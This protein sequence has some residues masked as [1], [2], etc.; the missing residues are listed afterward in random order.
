M[1]D[2]IFAGPDVHVFVDSGVLIVPS[3]RSEKFVVLD[4]VVGGGLPFSQH[5]SPFPGVVKAVVPDDVVMD[6]IQEMDDPVPG[7]PAG[8]AF[9]QAV[10][11]VAHI[12]QI[13]GIPSH[14]AARK[15]LRDPDIV[16]DVVFDGD[17]VAVPGIHGPRIAAFHMGYD[18]ILD[19]DVGGIF[20]VYPDG[21]I[22][23]DQTLYP[24]V[25]PVVQVNGPFAPSHVDGD[26]FIAVSCKSDG[27]SLGSRLR[28]PYGFLVVPFSDVDGVPRL[29][30]GIG[31]ADGAPG[32]VYRAG[33]RIRARS[34]H[35]I[36]IHVKSAS[37]CNNLG[38]LE[39]LVEKI[40]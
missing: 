9:D 27:L 4:Q 23:Q 1:P 25:V 13:A 29:S 11:E 12:D 15:I 36:F 30:G 40:G 3:G 16:H 20:G 22:G 19:G 24:D 31:F 28:G 18:T 34:A 10:M 39:K 6:I 37:L 38:I 32:L 26:P 21:S 8:I 17:V 35:G 7:Q 2:D 33:I 5:A 14:L